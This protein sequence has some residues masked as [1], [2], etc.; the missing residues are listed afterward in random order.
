MPALMDRRT[1]FVYVFKMNFLPPFATIFTLH[2]SY[3]L[4]LTALTVH[5][6]TDLFLL[7]ESTLVGTLTFVFCFLFFCGQLMGRR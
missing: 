6:I 3:S 1:A 7:C 4:T 5:I 2:P